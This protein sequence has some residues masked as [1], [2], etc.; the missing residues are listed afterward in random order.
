MILFWLIISLMIMVALGFILY[1][2]LNNKNDLFNSDSNFNLQLQQKH[3]HEL[4]L[5]NAD[6]AIAKQYIQIARNELEE[7][8]LTNSK[9][10]NE[11]HSF[12]SGK[13]IWLSL[14]LLFVIPTAALL[15]YS[16]WGDSRQLAQFIIA[17]QIAV[18]EQQMREQL[19]SPQQVIW[20]LKQHL[21]E[22]PNSA[23]G[24][25]LLGRLYASQQQLNEAN[26]AYAHALQLSPHNIDI[27][28]NFAQTLSLQ[29]NNQIN[30]QALKLIKEI[31][32]IQPENNDARNLLAIYAYQHEDYQTAIKNWEIILPHLAANSVDRQNLIEA[33]AQAQ[34]K[35]P[36]FKS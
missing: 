12:I 29:N 18:K 21:L 16:N 35:K 4:S 30:A 33:I 23:Q 5:E 6:G 27:L 24:W 19:G 3:L 7:Q 25:Y 22:D 32:V 20:Q 13:S 11:R 8:I 1:P 10:Q 34:N 15:F 14:F 26:L 36:P 31:L 28:M 17:Q 9:F 2:L